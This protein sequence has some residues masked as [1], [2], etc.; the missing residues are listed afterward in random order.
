MSVSAELVAETGRI[1]ER[2][3][4]NAADTTSTNPRAAA[5]L[6]DARVVLGGSVERAEAIV[7]NAKLQRPGVCNALECLLVH[8]SEAAAFV[9]RLQRLLDAGCEIRGD[10]RTVALLDGGPAGKDSVACADPARPPPT[11]KG[12]CAGCAVRADHGDG[13]SAGLAWLAALALA[14]GLR[15]ARAH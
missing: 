14:L 3:R 5:A 4:W 2:W 8:R 12:G 11:D 9:P 6:R 7:H 13:G 10:A 1:R 15:R